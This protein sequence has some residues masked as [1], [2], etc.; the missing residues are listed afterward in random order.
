MAGAPEAVNRL[1]RALSQGETILVHGDYDVDGVAGAALFTRWLGRLGGKPV[2][3]VP[4]RIRDGYDLGDGGIRRGVEAGATLL[5]TVDSGILAHDAVARATAQGMDV[6]V[7]DHHQPGD[8]L[9]PALAVV[10]PSRRDC[11]YPEKG[12]CGTAV[13]WKLLTLLVEEVGGVDP[14]ELLPSLDLVALATI[15]DLVP[16]TGEN[17]ILVSYGLRALAVSRNVG[18]QALKEVSGVGA[19]A[20]TARDVG[21]GLGPRLNAA[22]R[23]GESE[24]ALRL[25]LTDDQREA[26]ELARRLDGEN[27]IRREEEQRTTGEALAGLARDFRP[28]RDF[29][30]VV[31]GEGWHP[32]VI[33]IVASRLVERVHRP[34]V[35]M[36]LDGQGGGRGSARSVTG[37]HLTQTLQGCAEHLARFGGHA[38]AAGMD[39]RPGQIQAFREAFNREARM[40]FG[41]RIPV[42]VLRL[43]ADVRLDEITPEFVRWL[44]YLGP[45]GMG[46]PRPVFRAREVE[47]ASPPRLLKSAHLKLPMRQGSSRLDGIGF[48]LGV[49]VP[50]DVVPR[51]PFDVAF[52][53][54]V[55]TF[56]GREQVEARIRDLKAPGGPIP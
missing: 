4:H 23:M 3:F 45:H 43:D 31:W 56:R 36:T 49:R 6:I 52:Q 17:R 25:L 2:P 22:G 16:L 32:G 18:L 41:G 9:P 53:L 26:A 13:V 44:E 40:A 19:G 20:V 54:A 37:L 24:A 7:T 5:V 55:S 10:N 47:S 8:T 12:L 35:V 28:E 48:G 34:T 30:L 1:A 39:L 15:A 21:F 51:G 50:P 46:N 33:G 14:K 11:P 27:I 42:P 29:G 38:Q